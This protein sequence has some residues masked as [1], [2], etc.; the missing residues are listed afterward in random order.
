MEAE[1]ND[2]IKE[3]KK[4]RITAFNVDELEKENKPKEMK[5][6]FKGAEQEKIKTIKK[7]EKALKK[8]EDLLKPRSGFKPWENV[9]DLKVVDGKPV[10]VKKDK[11]ERK[12][13]YKLSHIET[14]ELKNHIFFMCS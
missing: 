12:E 13:I 3:D 7:G 8:N 10:L 4:K 1:E 2:S 5:A 11:K 9:T 14:D 6:V